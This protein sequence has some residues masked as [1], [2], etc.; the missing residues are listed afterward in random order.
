MRISVELDTKE[1]AKGRQVQ[2][3]FVQGGRVRMGI[4]AH[5]HV[6]DWDAKKGKVKFGVANAALINARIVAQMQQAERIVLERPG[7]TPQQ[8]KAAMLDVQ[9]GAEFGFHMGDFVRK[10]LEQRKQVHS[11]VAK[12]AGMTPT[13]FSDMLGRTRIGDDILQRVG[14]AMGVDLLALVRL[15]M[16]ARNM[17]ESAVGDPPGAYQPALSATIPTSSART[18]TI[19]LDAFDEE[20]QLRILRFIQQQ[21]T[22]QHR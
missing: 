3:V 5:V 1:T 18:I 11:R 13:N 20:T 8:L 22:K 12:D 14:A 9:D 17:H 21:K 6:K 4:P 7:L 19:D 2:L 15:R 16:D 10:L